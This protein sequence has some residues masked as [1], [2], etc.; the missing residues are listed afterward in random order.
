MPKALLPASLLW[1]AVNLRSRISWWSWQ[2]GGFGCDR[3]AF[4]V[5]HCLRETEEVEEKQWSAGRGHGG[6]RRLAGKGDAKHPGG[7][8]MGHLTQ[9]GRLGLSKMS[10]CQIPT[11][12]SF[13]VLM[14]CVRAGPNPWSCFKRLLV[15]ARALL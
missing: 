5:I 10:S 11:Q 4:E 14:V 7:M 2:L 1:P 12:I 9:E 3:A 8:D 15:R 13:S 6:W